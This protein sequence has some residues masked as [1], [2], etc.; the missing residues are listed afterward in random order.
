MNDNISEMTYKEFTTRIFHYLKPHLGKLVIAS[1]F[2]VLASALESSIPEITG[3]I[4][5]EVFN[6]DRSSDQTIFYSLLILV[7]ITLSA[8]FAIISASTSSWIANKVVMEIRYEMFCKLLKLPKSFFDRNNS[9]NILSKFTYDVHQIAHATS[10]IWLDFI[11]ATITVIILFLYLLYK[12]W[13]LTIGLIF[14][15]PII[16]LI[17]QKS[18]I[19]MRNS[20]ASVQESMGDIAH[21][22]NENVSGNSIIKMYLA[23]TS[24]KNKFYE[25]VKKVRQQRFKVDLTA[26]FNSN[27]VNILLG[28]CL[29]FV[30]YLS[31]IN[32][33][34]SAG[35]FL[36]YFTALAMIIKPTKTLININK[37][38]QIAFAGAESVF[39][40]MDEIEENNPG[41]KVLKD[42]KKNIVF[43]EISFSYDKKVVLS[44][45]SLT[46]NKGET[47]AIVGPTGSGKTTIIQLLS[48]FYTPDEGVISID[49]VKLEDISNES[50]R[51][52]IAFVDQGA[53]LFNETVS[54]NIAL[55]QEDY[56][57]TEIIGLSAKKAE[58]AEFINNLES[59]FDTYIGDNGQLLSGG[60]RQRLAISRAIAKNAPILILDEA[61]SALDSTTEKLVQKAI[62]QLTKGKTTIVIAHR[63]ST[64]QNADRIIVMKSGKI[65]EEGTHKDLIKKQGYYSQLVSDQFT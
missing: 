40:F 5:D 38:L 26:A 54:N 14:V 50:L 7:V 15:I 12:N 44:N 6:N 18:S 51:K 9:G 32:L 46:I 3:Q 35:D 13:Q 65:F 37:P 11:K 19:R 23:E 33:S 64:I 28:V 59:K 61:T 16:F 24:Q 34:L 42:L 53:R 10:S 4:I 25:L 60:Q 62:S 63:L 45:F 8:L 48:K 43:D 58:A 39:T 17:V 47:I 56:I 21:V 57:S 41:L 49:G 1:I 31:A 55:G 2:M 30:V 22:V 36:S 29:S 52:N 27:F 20:S